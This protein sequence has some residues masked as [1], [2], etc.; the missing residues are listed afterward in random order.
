[1]GSS[2]KIHLP[3]GSIVV[4]DKGYNDYKA[5]NRFSK[6]GVSWVTR[7]HKHLVYKKLADHDITELQQGK[8]VLYDQQIVLG[9]EY[10]LK[11]K[12]KSPAGNFIDPHQGKH[13]SSYQ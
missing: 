5:F 12:S 4:F 9:V 6:E 2:M 3:K 8:G 1:M 7:L 11:A 13:L 10:K